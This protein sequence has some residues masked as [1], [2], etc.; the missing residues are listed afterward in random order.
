MHFTAAENESESKIWELIIQN[1]DPQIAKKVS[2]A[3]SSFYRTEDGIE[4]SIRATNGTLI[5]SG[6]SESD[7]MGNRRWSFYFNK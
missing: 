4:C 5:A 1:L 7:R 6:Y 3:S 2:S